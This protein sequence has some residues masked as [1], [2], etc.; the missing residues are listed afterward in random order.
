VSR[1]AQEENFVE[2]CNLK[3][4]PRRGIFA[5]FLN[6]LKPSAKGCLSRGIARRESKFSI[7]RRRR[8]TEFLRILG[9]KKS[10]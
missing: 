4:S 1:Q 10:S 8:R 3:K 6:T 5:R 2:F 9:E 7:C